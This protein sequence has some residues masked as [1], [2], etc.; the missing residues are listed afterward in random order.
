MKKLWGIFATLSISLSI[1]ILMMINE[2]V[3]AIKYLS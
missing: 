2:F 3:E 1:L